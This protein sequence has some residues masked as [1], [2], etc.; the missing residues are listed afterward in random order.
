MNCP[1]CGKEMVKGCLQS[2]EFLS[3][4]QKKV[5]TV[6]TGMMAAEMELGFSVT[7]YRCDACKKLVVDYAE[8]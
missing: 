6:F 5:P 7:A 4:N 1:F 2:R 8:K 3:W